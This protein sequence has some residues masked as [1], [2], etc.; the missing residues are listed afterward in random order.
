MA[1]YRL[2]QVDY[3]GQYDYSKTLKVSSSD[4]EFR[5]VKLSPNPAHELLRI[6]GMEDDAFSIQV[7]DYLGR[8]VM[9]MPSATHSNINIIDLQPGIYW[10][11]IKSEST[12][13]DLP[14]IKL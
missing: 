12:V 6:E 10:I 1:Y 3:D 13:Q 4:Y 11:K 5:Q 14:F 2:R 7:T 8:I 9:V